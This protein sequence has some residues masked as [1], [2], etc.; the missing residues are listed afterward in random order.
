M[1]DL[2]TIYEGVSL[3]SAV[4][5]SSYISHIYQHSTSGSYD[6]W[7]TLL[8][9]ATM[10]RLSLE[11]DT[12][13]AVAKNSLPTEISYQATRLISDVHA[14]PGITMDTAVTTAWAIALARRGH[15]QDQDVTFRRLVSG[16]NVA[17]DR[18]D[19]LPGHV[20]TWFL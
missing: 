12:S 5:F 8:N 16:R 10:T 7:R 19:R 20:S 2:G 3:P 4:K 6:Y 17:L 11:R 1:N 14:P 15:S 9:G 18:A 13:K